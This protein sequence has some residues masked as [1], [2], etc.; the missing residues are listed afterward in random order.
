MTLTDI[1]IC[2]TSRYHQI[3]IEINDQL[4][5]RSASFSQLDLTKYKIKDV[6]TFFSWRMSTFEQT[7]P[8]KF[9]LSAG[10]P[11]FPAKI[12]FQ[13]PRFMEIK[14]AYRFNGLLW[15]RVKETACRNFW[16]KR[17]GRWKILE[18]THWQLICYRAGAAVCNLWEDALH[19]I[20]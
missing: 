2:L 14:I 11:N 1:G 20:L 9:D 17:D 6:T 8:Y 19:F 16:C 5:E 7:H 13:K 15:W 3:I 12:L 4:N 18:I 10:R